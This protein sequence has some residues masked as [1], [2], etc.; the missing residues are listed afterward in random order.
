[1]IA[2]PRQPRD[3]LAVKRF[4]VQIPAQILILLLD[5]EIPRQMGG[6][7]IGTRIWTGTTYAIERNSYSC[8]FIGSNIFLIPGHENRHDECGR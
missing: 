2:S 5:F 6:D 7:E 8:A 1:M 4:G 3:G